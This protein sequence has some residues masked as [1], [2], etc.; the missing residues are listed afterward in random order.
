MI[1]FIWHS[2]AV[3]KLPS[4]FSALFVITTNFN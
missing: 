2:V 1:G 3:C 4:F